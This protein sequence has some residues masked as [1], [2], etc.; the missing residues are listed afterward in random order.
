METPDKRGESIA[1]FGGALAL[2]ASVILFILAITCRS[3]L[4]W[5]AGF[6]TLGSAGI[7]VLTLIQL[8]QYRLVVEERMEVAELERQR[9]EML[10][11]SRS[12]FEEQDLEQMD[13]L[14]M[15]RR[16]RWIERIVTPILALALALYY[17]AAGLVVLPVGWQLPVIATA[18]QGPVDR[19]SVV[20]FFGA[21]IAFVFFMLSRYSLA[22]SRAGAFAPMRAAGNFS[23]GVSAAGLTISLAMLASLSG[24]DWIELLLGRAVAGLLVVL[25]CE[26][27]LNFVLDFY[28]PRTAG[29]AQRP[30]YD[31]RLLGMFS[32]PGGILRSLTD[33]VDYQFGFRVSQT[34]FYQLMG[35]AV[36]PLLLVQ[37][38]V[39]FALTCIVA[40]PPGHQAVVEHLGR[41]PGATLK[42]GVHLVWFWP[43]DR[44]TI[45]PVERI[46]RLEIG[47][48]LDPKSSEEHRGAPILWTRRHYKKEYQLLIGD[49]AAAATSNSP[50]NLVSVNMPV[51][52]RVKDPDEQVIRFYS[53]SADV[54]QLIESLAYR[55][56]TQ[57]AAQADL[58][59]LL[60]AG[61]IR[62]AETLHQRIQEACDRA[63]DDG[64]GLGVR[65][66]HVGI[67]GMHP[68][69]DDEVAKSFEEVVSAVETRDALIKEAQG[70]AAK[71]R[72]GSAGSEWP[73]LYDAIVKEDAAAKA[74][75]PELAQCLS[76]VERLLGSETGGRAREIA[77]GARRRAAI[78]VLGERASSE[79]YQLQTAAYE[80]DPTTYMLRSY[81][82]L[83]E[84]GLGDV[85]KY[86]ILL[87]DSD[88]VIYE[89]DLKPPQG[90]DI[91]GAELSA[92]ESK[93]R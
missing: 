2:V 16:L 39:L 23:F 14:A 17:L 52:W 12:I 20:L 86:V 66:V 47:Y 65:I 91:L 92:M 76:D 41:R 18:G 11:G 88:R 90:I 72:V 85:N 36:L 81:L 69:P 54:P 42:P 24:F 19:P 74:K 13:S 53:Q 57:F 31:S 82:R 37:V 27:A 67:G 64:Q 50:I 15:A 5:A 1:L 3:T 79:W 71:I 33:A 10:G 30:F 38:A 35:R 62:A 8:H 78:R 46:A 77:S 45:V 70:E 25:A 60:G 6:M 80:A 61:G 73:R 44:A 29:Q 84:E 68:P 87:E 63:G 55:E 28:R 26:C 32:E 4:V 48:E 22:M 49:R 56:L 93:P 40:V 21:G 58:F 51:Q 89:L 34:W 75:S 9:Q 83:L 43:I 59:D 7:W